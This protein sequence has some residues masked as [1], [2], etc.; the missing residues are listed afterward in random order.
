MIIKT[1]WEEFER[2]EMS[3]K[4]LSVRVPWHTEGWTGK[5]CT[6]PLDNSFCRILPKINEEKGISFDCEKCKGKDN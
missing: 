1:A 2:R 6:N 5:I 3:I 4:H